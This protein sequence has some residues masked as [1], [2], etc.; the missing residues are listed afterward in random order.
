MKTKTPIAE[1]KAWQ[2]VK[3]METVGLIK[4]LNRCDRRLT[5]SGLR[6]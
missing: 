6:R 2:T 3:L 4:K 1:E 5:L